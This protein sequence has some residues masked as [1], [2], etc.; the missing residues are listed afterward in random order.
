M[1]GFSVIVTSY[2]YR[3][4]VAEAVDGAL[5]QTRAAEEVIVVDDGSSDGSAE[6][7]R[8]RYGGDPRVTLLLCGQNGGQAAAFRQGIARARAGVLCFL[9]ADDRWGPE[10]LA[11]IG[12]VYDARSDVDFVLSDARVFGRQQRS[13]EYANRPMDLGRTVY[14]TAVLSHWS[15]APS[16]ALSLRTPWA[17][18]L[19]DLPEEYVRDWRISADSCLVLGASILGLRKYYL[20]TGNVDYRIHEGNEACSCCRS[21]EP[22]VLDGN[23][24]RSR[25]LI[26]HYAGIAGVDPS[27]IERSTFEFRSKPDP[28]WAEAR[29]YVRVSMRSPAPWRD[30]IVGAVDILVSWLT[31]R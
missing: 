25:R 22:A 8:Q 10:Y 31:S 3:S 4:F 24:A 2:N 1:T 14:S 19:L 6:F 29:R 18:R 20:P 27:S 11:R 16:S 15:G 17:R 23:R 28:T 12:E 5:A 30:R 26:D 7:L 9:D 21:T 13:I